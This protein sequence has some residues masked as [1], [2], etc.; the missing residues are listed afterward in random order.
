MTTPKQQL[1]EATAV[2]ATC[3]Q[4]MESI[5]PTMEAFMEESR[6]MESFGPIVDPTLFNS[7]ERRAAE[8]LIKPIFE[9]GLA[10]LRTYDVQTSAGKAA[11]EK[12]TT[13]D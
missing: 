2:L 7:S 12:V 10:F 11:L 1:M 8:A 4:F 9:S 5:R 6:H 3:R 13:D